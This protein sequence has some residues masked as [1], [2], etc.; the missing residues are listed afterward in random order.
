MSEGRAFKPISDYHFWEWL[1]QQPYNDS[2]YIKY[3][4]LKTLKYYVKTYPDMIKR[5][6]QDHRHDLQHH[7][8]TQETNEKILSSY[9]KSRMK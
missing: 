4:L 3:F 9:I 7:I 1:D 2:T 5:V 8:D 6:I